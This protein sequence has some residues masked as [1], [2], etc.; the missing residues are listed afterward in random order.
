[1]TERLYYHDSNLLEF[2]GTITEVGR[3]GDLYYTVLDRSAFYPTSGGQSHDNGVLGG[4]MVVDVTVAD[5]GE[6]HH[7]TET[8]IGSVGTTV[9]GRIDKER[10]RRNC[11][12]HTAQHLLSAAF[13]RLFGLRTVSVH[14]GEEYGAVE[15]NTPDVSEESLDQAERLANEVIRDNL[16]VNTLFVDSTEAGRLPLRKPPPKEGTLRIIRIDDFEC[17]ACG[18]T[19]CS[20]TGGV[21]LIKIIGTE[22][23]RGNSLVKFLSGRLAYEDYGLRFEVSDR[24]AR[25][26]TCHPSDLPSRIEKMAGENKELRRQLSEAR[27]AL[28]PALV[29]RLAQTVSTA[30]G[31]PTVIQLLTEVDSGQLVQLA[32]QL[33]ERIGGLAALQVNDRIVLAASERS[34]RKAG[35]LARELAAAADLKG[36]GND[37]VAQLGGA[38]ES[39]IDFY[40]E[41]LGKLLGA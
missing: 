27:K 23:L 22:K 39:R 19:H 40:R 2:E 32:G 1:M 9:S 16:A 24:L 14:L 17:S 4:A 38:D 6:V 29:D 3:S 26:F 37:R 13:G 33:A 21:G 41:K 35:A 12:N 31:L 15:L 28:L 34:G 11:Q 36:G 20:T 30:F 10:R 18:G 25:Q 5:S 7:L 8:A